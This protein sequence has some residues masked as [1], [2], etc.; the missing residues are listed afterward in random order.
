M[1]EYCV[2]VS[3]TEFEAG[4]WNSK[5]RLLAKKIF[6]DEG[7]LKINNVLAKEYVDTLYTAYLDQLDFTMDKGV[8]NALCVGADRYMS[9]VLVEGIFNDVRLYANAFL[10]PV[11]QMILGQD[12]MLNSFGAVVAFPGSNIQHLHC[13]HPSL[14]PDDQM[15]RAQLPAFA[16]TVAMPLIDITGLN[17]PTLVWPYS[18]QVDH[19]NPLANG[20]SEFLSGERGC[21]YLWDYQVLHG[22]LPNRSE[23]LRPLLYLTYSRPWF[24][25]TVNFE[26]LKPL[27]ITTDELKKVPDIYRGL[28]ANAAIVAN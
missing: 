26:T 15:P 24:S 12:C 17:G 11:I 1:P 27:G 16:I 6:Q 23:Q 25:D 18:A 9:E 3:N 7:I 19:D 28:F 10:F 8:N 4:Q 5:K 2:T 14:F 22:G 20:Y 13:D 21:C